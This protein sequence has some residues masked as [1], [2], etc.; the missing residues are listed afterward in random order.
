[1]NPPAASTP[2]CTQ[3]PLEFLFLVSHG[4]LSPISAI[5]W[6]TSR[7]ERL[8]KNMPEEQR[9]IVTHL[10]E[11]ARR[12]STAF[13]S[14]LLLA[15]NDDQTYALAP[16][17]FP[18]SS[19]LAVFTESNTLPKGLRLTISGPEGIR[20]EGDR[21][22]LETA[23]HN[24]FAVLGEACASPCTIAVEV[25]TD[26]RGVAVRFTCP[27]DLTIQSV[28]AAND[29]AIRAVV[30]GTPGLLLS[31]THSLLGFTG[32]SVQMHEAA[33]GKYRITVRLAQ[34]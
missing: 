15:R 10:H 22:L 24:I 1:M 16:A 2:A 27:L 20:V 3:Q 26:E 32:G 14:M 7:L 21:T 6:G 13:T 17:A 31:L 30:G 25:D 28:C 29:G 34:G 23:F 5:R 9:T 18:L 8:A 33:D 11:N 12:L 19:L 4:L